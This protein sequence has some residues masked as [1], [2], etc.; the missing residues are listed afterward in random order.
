M[1]KEELISFEDEI[2]DLF[3]AGKIHAPVHL[4][5]GN[6]DQLINI[7]RLIK[8]TDWVFS[9]HRSHYHALLKG[10]SPALIKKEILEGRSICLR[11]PEYYF[12]S[13][14]IVAGCVPQA[15]GVAM[16]L[17]LHS[18]QAGQK[19]W[20]FVGDMAAETGVFHECVKYARHN[21]LPI[22]FVV[23]DNGLSVNTPTS[24]VWGIWLNTEV[25]RYSYK[26]KFPHQGSGA[27]V[28]F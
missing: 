20:C 1:N 18:V 3:E 26:P 2:K 7:F 17:R 28:Q 15:V 25:K 19:V 14:A 5:G 13:S 8:N 24:G 12:Y 6:E 9:T 21:N 10:V 22:E 11:F 16:T 4:S 27:W 23:E